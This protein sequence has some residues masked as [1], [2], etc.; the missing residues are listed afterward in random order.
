MF[1]F[2]F[3]GGELEE[4]TLRTSIC[5]GRIVESRRKCIVQS[6]VWAKGSVIASKLN[7]VFD[8]A[9]EV[10]GTHAVP[11]GF[12]I[13]ESRIIGRYS[14]ALMLSLVRINNLS[15][16]AVWRS[17]GMW[18]VSMK[19]P[20]APVVPFCVPGRWIR[21]QYTGSPLR[22]LVVSLRLIWILK[23]VR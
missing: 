12:L 23:S 21:Q 7:C 1:H 17:W 13:G 20:G 4:S 14:L 15:V 16:G 6:S 2:L 10:W 8:G 19:K 22:S 11:G 5:S 18:L 3:F 9:M